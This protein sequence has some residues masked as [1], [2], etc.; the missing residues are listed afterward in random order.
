MGDSDERLLDFLDLRFTAAGDL[1]RD[2]L[3]TG[4]VGWLS[5]SL[6]RDR[7]LTTTQHNVT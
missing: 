7:D 6:E 3:T 5:R 2:F 4:L 1:D